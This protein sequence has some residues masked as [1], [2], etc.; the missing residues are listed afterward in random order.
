V[1]SYTFQKCTPKKLEEWFGLRRSVVSQTLDRW[2]QTE[3][4]PSE[5]E[6]GLLQHLQAILIG[7][8]DAWNEQEL[9]LSLTSSHNVKL[10]QY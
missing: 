4:E 6:S 5:L 3:S 2:L 9:A 8:A 7:N 10:V 1:K